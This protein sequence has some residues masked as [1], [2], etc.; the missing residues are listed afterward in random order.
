MTTLDQA[1]IRAYSPAVVPAATARDSMADEGQDSFE[2]NRPCD[3]PTI[4]S[5]SMPQGSAGRTG[6]QAAFQVDRFAWSPTASK[7]SLAAGIQLDRLA[8]GLAAGH[9]A[10][11]I[12][13]GLGACCRAEGCTTLLLCAARR[14]AQRGLNVLLVDA[15][16]R[17]PCLARRL[18]LLPEVGWEDVLAGRVPATEAMVESSQDGLTVLPLRGLAAE[19]DLPAGV[20]VDPGASLAVLREHF[21]L[22]LVDLGE[23]NDATPAGQPLEAAASWLDGVVLVH[24]VRS[25]PQAELLRTRN[26]LHAAGIAEFGIAENFV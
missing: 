10:G 19:Q 5:P 18:G 24:N 14:L 25:T 12:V 20:P 8:D 3:L 22:V 23:L 16:F 9:S 4:E 11:R 15:D 13:I 2:A 1:F 17:H 26:R 7:L 6:V 21:D